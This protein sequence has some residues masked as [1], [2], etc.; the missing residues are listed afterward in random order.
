MP[1]LTDGIYRIVVVTDVFGQ[2][3]R[4]CQRQ[5]PREQP[6]SSAAPVS[7]VHPDLT[8]QLLDAPATAVSGNPITLT[9][10]IRNIGTGQASGNWLDRVYLSRDQVI[11]AGDLLVRPTPLR[12]RWLP[13]PRMATVSMSTCRWAR[14]EVISCRRQP[15]RRA[16]CPSLVPSPTIWPP[17]RST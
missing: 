12:V 17:D 15:T 16:H 1:A 11:D 6:G 4:R 3:L 13:E 5:R 14:M 9:Y 10:S 8:P 2:I 7:V